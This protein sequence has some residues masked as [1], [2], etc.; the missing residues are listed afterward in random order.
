MSTIIAH[1]AV[2][3]PRAELDD[4]VRIGHHCVIGAGV[5]IGRGTRL[6]NNVTI[7]VIRASVAIITCSR[8]SSSARRTT[9]PFLQGHAYTSH[10]R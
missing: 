1:T 10:H 3:D 7:N 5:Q 8:T 4:E 2:V 9:R 6:E